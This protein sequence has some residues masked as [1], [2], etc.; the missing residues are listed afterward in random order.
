MGKYLNNGTGA[1]VT[2]GTELYKLTF[3][4][5]TMIRLPLLIRILPLVF[6]LL[7]NTGCARLINAKAS[8]FADNLGQTMLDSNDP[9]TVAES[10]PT[11]IV[12]VESMVKGSPEDPSLLKAAAQLNSTYATTFI[13]NDET[14]QKTLATNG[15]N[16]AKQ[17]ACFASSEFCNI[18]ELAFDKV[19]TIKLNEDTRP[20]AYQLAISWLG[21]IQTHSNDWGAIAHLPKV[22]HIFEQI[23][24]MDETYEKGMPHL[25]L[26]G[27]ATLVP[28]ALGGKPDVGKH[29]FERAIAIS[30]GKNLMAKVEYARRYARMMF[31]QPLHNRLLSEVNRA[32]A[33][34]E[35]LT[36]ANVLAKKQAE[37]LLTEE[38][39]YFF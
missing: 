2:S 30:D 4:I 22:K 3:V 12:L 11:F 6:V 5:D 36:L 39:D 7:L 33:K 17:A 31:D 1:A 28:P 10:M 19:Q 26:A 32:D 34:A 15:F 20:Y 14:R 13:N 37:L 38:A 9:A 21:Y 18:E 8:A 35:G 27:I 16:Y 24:T 23:I 25:Y 29:H